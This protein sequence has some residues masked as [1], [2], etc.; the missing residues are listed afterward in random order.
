LPVDTLSYN[1]AAG[2]SKFELK[3]ISKAVADRFWTNEPRIPFTKSA[4]LN[5]GNDWCAVEGIG[6]FEFYW[7]NGILNGN[8]LDYFKKAKLIYMPDKQVNRK[9]NL[10]Y[11][12]KKINGIPLK[13]FF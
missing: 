13:D 9:L 7:D 6:D 11:K 4:G 3:N 10:W 5:K 12:T 1:N 8:F 2:R